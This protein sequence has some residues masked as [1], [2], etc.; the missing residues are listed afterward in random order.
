MHTSMQGYIG[1]YEAKLALIRLGCFI[2]EDT[3]GK[4]PIDF[5]ALTPDGVLKRVQ[6]KSTRQVSPSGYAKVGIKTVRSNKTTNLIKGYDKYSCD[7]L[8]VFDVIKN[9]VHLLDSSKI[10]VT[11][12]ITLNPTNLEKLELNI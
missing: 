10:E 3:S 7:I 11:K 9:K 5:I 12:E 6:V 2:F 8:A 1:E 4:A